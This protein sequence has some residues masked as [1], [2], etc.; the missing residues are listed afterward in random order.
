[1]AQ[2]KQFENKVK[3]FLKQQGFWFIKYWGGAAF[4]QAG[5]PDILAC[6]SGVFFGIELKAENGKPSD[7]QLYNLRQI[8][9]AGGV[10][11]LL[12]PKEFEHFKRAVLSYTRSGNKDILEGEWRPF[13]K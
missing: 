2:E 1:M 13:K 3:S 9:K 5:V 6:V 11:V 7:L 4:T 10:G 8:E 12:Y